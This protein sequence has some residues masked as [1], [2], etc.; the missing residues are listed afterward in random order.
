MLTTDELSNESVKIRCYHS[1]DIP[2]EL[3]GGDKVH[4]SV[5]FVSRS[6]LPLTPSPSPVGRGWPKD[7]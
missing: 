2:L 1:A 6:R 3:V 4:S 5:K 7:G